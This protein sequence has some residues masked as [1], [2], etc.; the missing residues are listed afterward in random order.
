MRL[1]VVLIF[2]LRV[3]EGDVE[4]LEPQGEFARFRYI[5]RVFAKHGFRGLSGRLGLDRSPKTNELPSNPDAL[6]AMLQDLGPVAVKLGQVLATRDDLIAPQWTMALTGLQDNVAPVPY[7]RIAEVILEE[8]GAPPE[9]IFAEFDKMPLAAASI[10]QVYA[11]KLMSG[12]DVVVKVRRPGIARLVDA[13]FRLL[14]RLA[15]LAERRMPE[16]ARLRPDE[17][18]RAFSEGLSSEMDLA[19][20]ARA[21]EEVGQFLSRLGITVPKFY[22]EYTSQRVNV[23]QRLKGSPASNTS[24]LERAG[25]K[26][27]ARAYSQAVIRMI[28]FNGVYHADPHP[29]NVWIQDDGSMAFIDFG[30]VGRLSAARREEIVRLIIAI[31]S[32]DYARVVDV[33]LDW[34]GNPIVER[35][36]LEAD[37]ASLVNKF[38][39]TLIGKI[40]FS[41]IFDATFGLLRTHRLGLPPDLALMLRTLLIAEGVVQKIDPSFDIGAE[42]KPVAKELLFERLDPRRAFGAG[43]KTVAG[44]AAIA[45]RTPE[46][47]KHVEA[48]AKTGRVNV[49]V[50]S[51]TDQLLR[52]E[53]NRAARRLSLSLQIAAALISGAI[54]AQISMPIGMG[55]GAAAVIGI[56]FLAI[57]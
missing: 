44:L 4:D 39:G 52:A 41:E 28:L 18:L 10:A 29:G 21:G 51:Q 53:I 46:I 24:A 8:L 38:E 34:S 1:F 49:N 30:S 14:R 6:V 27:T 31:A 23:Q 33:L 13:D 16:V 42:L 15:R 57:K 5:A 7:E 25:E 55:I 45:L 54:V 3:A 17:L 12:E 20:E 9:E 35:I 26:A 32:S 43:K 56:L 37:I 19:A 50:E 2:I 40:D 22:W 47:L 48:F 36:K 11:A